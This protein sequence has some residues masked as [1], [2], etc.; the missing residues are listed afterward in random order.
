MKNADWQPLNG[1]GLIQ[2]IKEGKSIPLKWVNR[3]Q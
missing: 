3:P 1:N 2:L